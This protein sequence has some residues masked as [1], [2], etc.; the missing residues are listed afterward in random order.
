VISVTCLALLLRRDEVD[1][2][3]FQLHL[4]NDL[5]DLFLRQLGLGEPD[6][7]ERVPHVQWSI[8]YLG[9]V[10]A[11]NSPHLLVAA[12]EVIE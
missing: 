6:D 4:R 12:D 9:L 3:R 5:A 10:S 2:F 7:V 11:K 1:N 8:D